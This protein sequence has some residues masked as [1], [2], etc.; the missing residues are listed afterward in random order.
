VS[1][2]IAENSIRITDADVLLIFDCCHAGALCRRGGNPMA[3][4]M[5]PR[6]CFEFIAACD[7]RHTTSL[8]GET[9][10]TTALVWALNQLGKRSHFS[11]SE[12]L[13]KIMDAPNFP[14][15][16]YPQLFPRFEPTPEHI[17]ISPNCPEL[18][19]PEPS[20]HR[21][22]YRNLDRENLDRDFLDL[23]FQFSRPL[24]DDLLEKT[25]HILKCL[26]MNH[27]KEL[28]L[29]GI[30]FRGKVSW[31][32]TIQSTVEHWQRQRARRRAGSL[33]PL[34]TASYDSPLDS[35][36]V[37]RGILRRPV[38]P[39]LVSPATTPLSLDDGDETAVEGGEIT[40]LL[41][42]S[43]PIFAKPKE[44]EGVHYHLRMSMSHLQ[45][46]LMRMCGDILGCWLTMNER[47]R[48]ANAV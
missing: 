40:P 36:D 24:A 26:R 37:E 15:D 28:F 1:W 21:E 8:P 41:S 27:R 17:S 38:P 43:P 4:G 42:G 23:R 2:D 20:P 19:L 30:T 25:A 10:F 16:Q 22:E 32:Q 34:G 12:L 46:A 14:K 9:S 45:Q 3:N 47:N 48:N 5:Q 7:A 33:S 35:A 39:L 11:S 31:R 29:E 44:S 6:R 18:T 13:H